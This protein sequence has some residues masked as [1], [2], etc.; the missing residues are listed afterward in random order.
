MASRRPAPST[1]SR[2]ATGNAGNMAPPPV[3][4]PS[5]PR[6]VAARTHSSSTSTST[7]SRSTAPT[8]VPDVPA[9]PASI[10]GRTGDVEMNIQVV[11]RC[12]RRS[13][14]E[15]ADNS[16]IVVSSAGAKSD[17]LT[18]ETAAPSSTLGVVQLPPTRTYPF[19]IVFGPEADQAMVFNDVVQPMLD[20]VLQG[21]N[22]TL[23]A[24]GQ[25]GTGKTCVYAHS[26]YTVDT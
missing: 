19:D 5:R 26:I 16:P 14:R 25:T 18:I 8:P 6:S 3:A 17:A 12:R 11:L 7:T 4:G 15:V 21:Y 23:F 24:Y 2:S 9:L 13:E 1:R 20:E 10:R 22:C